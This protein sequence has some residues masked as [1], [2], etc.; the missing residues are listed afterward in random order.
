MSFKFHTTIVFRKLDN[1]AP[2]IQI[3]QTRD[4]GTETPTIKWTSNEDVDFECSLDDGEFFD[5][6]D[7]QTGSWIGRNLLDGPHK[8]V[9]RGKDP[10]LNTGQNTFTWNKGMAIVVMYRN[11]VLRIGFKRRFFTN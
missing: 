11:A 6:G 2:R 8:F 5:C 3:A 10:A 9:I 1:T 7:G 4:L